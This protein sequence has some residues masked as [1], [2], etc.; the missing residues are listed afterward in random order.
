MSSLLGPISGALVAGGIYYGFSAMIQTRTEQHRADLHRLSQR[1]L[2]A[3][4]SIPA[5]PA[6]VQRITHHP[7]A[8]MLKSQWN[9]Q[10]ETVFRTARGWDRRA[11]DWTR[12][13]LY[14]GDAAAEKK[15]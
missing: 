4:T 9:A 13:V 3:P 5:P 15:G 1:L 12:R 7:L 8:S 11:I 10:I 2:D 6:A 14:G